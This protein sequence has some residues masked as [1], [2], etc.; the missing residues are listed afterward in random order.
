MHVE[1]AT[2]KFDSMYVLQLVCYFMMFDIFAF[3]NS[4][5]DMETYIAQ[6]FVALGHSAFCRPG[7]GVNPT[8]FEFTAT[9]PG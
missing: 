1:L 3:G 9:T 4:D 6:F 7:S 5:F 8:T 2:Y